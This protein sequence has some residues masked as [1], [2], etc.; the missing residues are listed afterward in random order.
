MLIEAMEDAQART[1][2]EQPFRLLAVGDERGVAQR[3][4]AEIGAR[5]TII[6]AH[7]RL[8]YE[9]SLDLT[10][11]SHVLVVLEASLDEGIFLPSKFVDYVQVGRPV[12]AV[13]PKQGVLADLLCQHGGGL[14]VDCTDAA[15][16]RTGILTLY[17]AWKNGILDAR[18]NSRGLR[19][20]FSESTVVAEYRT[21]LD[22][23]MNR[24]GEV[25]AEGHT[26]KDTD[27]TEKRPLPQR[28]S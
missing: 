25:A 1:A 21:I 16:I 26:T 4:A 28:P 7:P 5:R 23:L 18:F 2:A 3:T 27:N 9:Q 11:Q 13:S 12:L 8:P 22:N 20:L 14:A 24:P 10:R 17:E 19:H 6:E 15:S